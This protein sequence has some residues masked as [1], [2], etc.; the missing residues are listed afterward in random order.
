M[1]RKRIFNL[2]E[3]RTNRLTKRSK[4]VLQLNIVAY[5][6][7]SSSNS[8]LNVLQTAVL[9]TVRSMGINN[10]SSHLSFV[11][12]IEQLFPRNC[13]NQIEMVKEYS[14][15]T[16]KVNVYKSKEPTILDR[17]KLAEEKLP[18][19]PPTL[20][21]HNIEQ[22]EECGSDNIIE[23]WREGNEV[24]RECGL[25]V[26]E[27]FL[28]M[29]SEWRTYADDLEQGKDK[30]RVG[31]GEHPLDEVL[32]LVGDTSNKKGISLV[33][34][35]NENRLTNVQV[36]IAETFLKIDGLAQ[37]LNLQGT[38]VRQA[39]DCSS[40]F[41]RHKN[42]ANNGK[43]RLSK[44]PLGAVLGG[45]IYLGCREAQVAR[46]LCEI[47]NAANVEMKLLRQKIIELLTQFPTIRAAKIRP[48]A[49]AT[50]WA[51]EID[52]AKKDISTVIVVADKLED[53]GLVESST[54]EVI[55]TYAVF[56][57]CLL[58]NE[59]VQNKGMLLKTLTN[60]TSNT[61]NRIHQKVIG[62]LDGDDIVPSIFKRNMPVSKIRIHANFK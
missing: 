27:R 30:S 22:C 39:K 48:S 2:I 61:M 10:S 35:A 7:Y 23:N 24:C 26:Q 45:C 38:A 11:P 4:S 52:M 62:K 13:K 9:N 8:L 34:K 29:G 3:D 51:T 25:V 12:S 37:K 59:D 36:Y 21:Q 53:S 42:E 1:P 6:P 60:I 32:A 33:G 14:N 18:K 46:S 56:L 40:A 49:F 16:P 15:G 28:D 57:V 43:Y 41:F 19:M 5:R 44:G 50:R 58:K 54:A 17:P 20:E 47:S 55:G 31:P